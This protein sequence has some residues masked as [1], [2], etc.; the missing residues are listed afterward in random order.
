MHTIDDCFKDLRVLN[1]D[2]IKEKRKDQ[3]Q[4][5]S[6]LVLPGE[7]NV[8]PLLNRKIFDAKNHDAKLTFS[9]FSMVSSPALSG[10]KDILPSI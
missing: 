10:G 4:A 5:V 8:E 2:H 7:L 9:K 6:D 1:R 3:Y